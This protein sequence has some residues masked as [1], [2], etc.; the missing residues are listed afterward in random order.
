MTYTAEVVTLPQE[1]ASPMETETATANARMNRMGVA[2]SSAIVPKPILQCRGKHCTYD[3][4]CPHTQQH[5]QVS[6][7][8][9]LVCKTEQ[10][11]HLSFMLSTVL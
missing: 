4:S 1:I 10:P 6:V 2:I 5:Q 9:S 8:L 11:E 7:L 3:C